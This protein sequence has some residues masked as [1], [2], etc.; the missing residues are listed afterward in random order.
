MSISTLSLSPNPRRFKRSYT[1]RFLD[2]QNPQSWPST[3]M[4]TYGVNKS[5]VLRGIEDVVFE[6]RP[7]PESQWSAEPLSVANHLIRL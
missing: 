4:S 1:D 7:V 3:T 6:E 5:F 2:E